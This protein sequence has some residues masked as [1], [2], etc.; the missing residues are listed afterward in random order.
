MEKVTIDFFD[1]EYS[2]LTDADETYVK[3]IAEFLEAKVKEANKNN[4]KISVSHPFLL[5]SL[6]IVDDFFRLQREF[7]EFKNSADQKSKS[8]VELLDSSSNYKSINQDSQHISGLFS[9]D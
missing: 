8:L 7:E 6:K 3:Q 9:T 4:K 5:A 2:I 1:E